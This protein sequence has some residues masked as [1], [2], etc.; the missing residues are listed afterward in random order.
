MQKKLA[1]K[2]KIE[3]QMRSWSQI[4]L[5]EAAGLSLRTVQRVETDGHCSAETLLAIAGA[6][7]LDIREFTS[8][9]N[10]SDDSLWTAD[11]RMINR[12]PFL[13]PRLLLIIA[14]VTT[15]SALIFLFFA[16]Q[17]LT[18]RSLIFIMA[19]TVVILCGVYTLARFGK[20]RLENCKTGLLFIGWVFSALGAAGLVWTLHL[21][22]TSGDFEYYGFVINGLLMTQ[23]FLSILFVTY[24]DVRRNA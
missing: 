20:H 11:R 16:L 10:M 22:I 21:G 6:F 4:Q 15:F 17:E 2:I 14:G 18:L 7:N 9:V 8:L 24:F 19:S 1:V 12:F 23:G 3:R 13:W 5:A